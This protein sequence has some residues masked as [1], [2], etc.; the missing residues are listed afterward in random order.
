MRRDRWKTKR[1]RRKE[2]GM[3][4]GGGRWEVVMRTSGDGRS[5]IGEAMTKGIK[6][7]VKFPCRNGTVQFHFG[8]GNFILTQLTLVL[9]VIKVAESESELYLLSQL[10]LI[11]CVVSSFKVGSNSIQELYRSSVKFNP[12]D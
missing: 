9:T 8:H 4:V 3:E 7:E 2:G 11:L 6:D 5:K 10:L 12:A 1:R